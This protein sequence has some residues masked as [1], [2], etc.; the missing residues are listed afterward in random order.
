MSTEGLLQPKIE[1]E[2]DGSLFTSAGRKRRSGRRRAAGFG[3]GDRPSK[4]LA[5]VD[6]ASSFD[7]S[8]VSPAPKRRKVPPPAENKLRTL[9][10]RFT[11]SKSRSDLEDAT[12]GKQKTT[13]GGQES[14]LRDA[15]GSR[16]NILV[17]QRGTSERANLSSWSAAESAFSSRSGSTCG[18]DSSGYGSADNCPSQSTSHLTPEVCASD[19]SGRSG[20][21][22]PC[23]QDSHT[24]EPKRS[25]STLSV[26]SGL[27]SENEPDDDD[28]VEDSV[29]KTWKPSSMDPETKRSKPVATKDDGDD[30]KSDCGTTDERKVNQ[31]E[32]TPE[33][34]PTK[35]V[36]SLMSSPLRLTDPGV[37]RF[38][39]QP[40]SPAPDSGKLRCAQ[41]P[42]PIQVPQPFTTTSTS[43]RSHAARKTNVLPPYTSPQKLDIS[44]RSDRKPAGRLVR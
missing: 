27:M 22:N 43:R 40:H 17:S 5:S 33:T 20:I 28:V 41:Y 7:S 10:R 34:K 42:T 35:P 11:S 6:S 23:V 19:L 36:E 18:S 25:R 15:S 38:P 9:F 14:G 16:G 8:W 3:F 4:S 24:T 32:S 44:P 37:P 26:R 30:R 29:W 39:E 13:R 1:A 2:R 21:V 12:Q 31:K